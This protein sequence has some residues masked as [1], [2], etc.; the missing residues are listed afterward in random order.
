MALRIIM[1]F[2]SLAFGDVATP[3]AGQVPAENNLE[4]KVTR[5]G[6]GQQIVVVSPDE[7]TPWEK[8]EKLC[9]NRKKTLVACG[10]LIQT[11]PK[12]AELKIT[13]QLELIRE[14]DIAQRMSPRE[15]ASLSSQ[16]DA[17]APP[18]R[19]YNTTLGLNLAFD[20][21]VPT[22]HFQG[23]VTPRVTAGLQ[24]GMILSNVAPDKLTSGGLLLTLNYYADSHF[25]GLWLQGGSGVFLHSLNGEITHAPAVIATVGWREEWA[26]GFNI[27]IG[28]GAR[29]IG[30]PK[31]STGAIAYRTINA[32]AVV[33]IGF[34]Y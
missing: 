34:N 26:L 19:T 30:P 14:G 29:Y 4:P 6:K 25:R 16:M 31:S 11:S 13:R 3:P 24:A 5:I 18:R 32:T 33:D 2:S 8:G 28:F 9:L 17:E 22:L 7:I 12:G 15:I 21:V 20:H 10:I 1:L 23:F 27:G